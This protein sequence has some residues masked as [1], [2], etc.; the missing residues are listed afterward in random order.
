MAEVSGA[1][2]EAA[3]RELWE[4]SFKIYEKSMTA[5]V[6]DQSL[7]KFQVELTFKVARS[8]DHIPD[9]ML[10]K[11]IPILADCLCECD[12]Y[13][14]D[15]PSRALQ[16]AAVHCLTR[17]ACVRDGRLIPHIVSSG[18]IGSMVRLLYYAQWAV[19]RLNETDAFLRVL[20]KFLWV[21]VSFGDECRDVLYEH[22]GVRAVTCLLNLMFHESTHRDSTKQFLLEILSA[23]AMVPSARK[24]IV[25]GEGLRYLVDAI[26]IGSMSSR[27]RACQAIGLIGASSKQLRHMIA[28]MGAIP[29][30]INL[31][32]E[33]D[34]ETKLVSANALALTLSHLRYIRPAA[35]AGVIPLYS[36]L[37]EESDLS[38]MAIA[39]DALCLLCV[40]EEN[41]V[42]VARHIVQILKDSNE[43]AK[44]NSCHVLWDIAA[45]KHSIPI[46][47]SSG[48][49]PVL[50]HLLGDS[51]FVR[52]K[53][54]SVI[55]KLSS[56]KVDRR[57]LVDAGVIPLLL[58]R[59]EDET[60]D[61][62]DSL[63]LDRSYA[64][65]S[66]LNF[67]E[68]PDC[69]DKVDEEVDESYLQE[70]KSLTSKLVKDHL[71][72]SD[73][74]GFEFEDMS[75]EDEDDSMV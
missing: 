70:L 52:Q 72:D 54:C 44:E 74:Y 47:Q 9:D 37:L 67:Y 25:D 55:A 2:R 3:C 34:S 11:A 5:E 48:A 20:L 73:C 43:Q 24:L 27:E 63:R 14:F 64:A 31:F 60:D 38:G 16:E 49:F 56:N 4:K 39:V 21:S 42:S 28:E 13:D 30:L 15:S 29:L 75:E 65:K 58:D 6:T 71:L 62:L 41:A 7:L 53:V 8:C 50:F 66:I 59:L 51:Y 40:A 33:G 22:G 26:G 17:I 18:V 61:P 10:L 45:Y 69:R 19:L 32:N 23:L 1:E 36:K 46:I 35:E 57:G 12:E 68:D